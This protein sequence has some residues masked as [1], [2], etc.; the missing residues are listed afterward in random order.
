MNILDLIVVIIFVLSILVGTFRGFIKTTMGFL[1]FIL[2]LILTNIFYPYVGSFLRSNDNLFI[3]L[4]NTISTALGLQN[5]VYD[6]A[7][8]TEYE[9]ISSLP[10]P[11]SFQNALIQNNTI[12]SHINLGANTFLEYISGFIT[13]IVINI[14]AMVLVFIIVYI[15]LTILTHFINFVAKLPVINGLN[16]ILGAAV[17]GIWGLLIIWFVLALS[18]LYF[19]AQGG[20]DI[21]TELENSNIARPLNEFN[22]MLNWILRFL[23]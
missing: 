20:F 10:L 4:R 18:T 23:P 5:A 13:S 6:A 9:I 21:Y 8:A 11:Q 14:I 16:K 12:S 17:G 22:F 15:G 3:S 19:S 2:S 1:K 7:Y